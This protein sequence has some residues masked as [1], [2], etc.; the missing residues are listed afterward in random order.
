MHTVLDPGYPLGLHIR[1][2]TFNA[3]STPIT[4]KASL[5]LT[6][7]G[8]AIPDAPAESCSMHTNQSLSSASSRPSPRAASLASANLEV[9]IPGRVN[10]EQIRILAALYGNLLVLSADLMQVFGG[11]VT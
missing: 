3:D 9:G 10:E 7:N 1:N 5:I 6:T 2:V 4:S 11:V 8:H